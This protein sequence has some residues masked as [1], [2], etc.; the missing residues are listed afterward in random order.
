MAEVKKEQLLD[1]FLEERMHDVLEQKLSHNSDY[2][3]AL[4]LQR[5]ELKK[6]EKMEWSKEQNESIGKAI[7]LINHCGAIYGEVAYKQGLQDGMKLMSEL[8]EFL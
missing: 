4:E 6:L 2:E 8:K 7:D 5:K 3:S 1:I